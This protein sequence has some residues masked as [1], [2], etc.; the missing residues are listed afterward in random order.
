MF[1]FGNSWYKLIPQQVRFSYSLID[2]SLMSLGGGGA[3][4]P[5][6][7]EVTEPGMHKARGTK[8]LRIGPLR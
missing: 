1:Q 7:G 4:G 2:R 8:W 3:G 5:S 6:Y